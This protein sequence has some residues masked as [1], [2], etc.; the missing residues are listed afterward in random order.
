MTTSNQQ[1]SGPNSLVQSP[2]GIWVSPN[3]LPTMPV[4]NTP[5]AAPQQ[6]NSTTGIAN[7]PVATPEKG[8]GRRNEYPPTLVAPAAASRAAGPPPDGPAPDP[9][10]QVRRHRDHWLL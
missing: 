9:L 5:A 8:P 3:F 1:H 4:T 10:D 7:T 2:G 6:Q